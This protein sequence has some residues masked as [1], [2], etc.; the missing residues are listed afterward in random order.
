MTDSAQIYLK[1]PEQFDLDAFAPLLTS[2]LDTTPVA[3]LRLSLNASDASALSRAADGLREIAHA[4]DVAI[5]IDDHFR[6]VE[7]HGLDGVHLTDGS[8]TIREARKVLG[9][10]A[11]IG[12]HCGGSRH[13]GITAAEIGVDYISFGPLADQGLGDS[14]VAAPDLFQWWSE[15]I[16]VP[17]VAEGGITD[18][19]LAGIKDFADFVCLGTEIWTAENPQAE[20]TRIIALLA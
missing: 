16:E 11:I 14:T 12:A 10:E 6:L 1:T 20:L 4:H 2:I 7:T 13:D 8:R 3:C 18:A 9:P 5:V 19:T 17:V 15:M